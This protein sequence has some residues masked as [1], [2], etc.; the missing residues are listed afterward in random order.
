MKLAH[1]AAGAGIALTFD[2]GPN[3]EH[4][5]ALLDVLDALQIK[6]HFFI[7]GKAVVERPQL[8][9]R[10]HDAGHVL[11]NH[12]YTHAH[13]T[14]LSPVRQRSELQ[15]CSAAIA[16]ITGSEPLWFRPPYFDTNED[17]QSLV[18]ELGMHSVMC[19]IRSRDTA[20]GA[21]AASVEQ[22]LRQTVV[23]DGIIL[24][25]EWSAASRQALRTVCPVWQKQFGF[26]ILRLPA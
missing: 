9:Q 1:N 8:A 4:T 22:S 11:C 26:G 5:P 25:H 13:V 16:D 14:R 6:A 18:D 7:V 19:S 17:L 20:E 23:A 15:Q 10:I 21:D 3:L 24:C 2:D 12:S